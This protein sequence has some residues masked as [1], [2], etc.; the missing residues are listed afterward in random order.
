MRGKISSVPLSKPTQVQMFGGGE[1]E[2]NTERMRKKSYWKV[3]CLYIYIYIIY[4]D[5]SRKCLD[6]Y[7]YI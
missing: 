7:K 4:I 1:S 2:L 3:C 6:V 5:P